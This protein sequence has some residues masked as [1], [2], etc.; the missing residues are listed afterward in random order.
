M[1]DN[2]SFDDAM[3]RAIVEYFFADPL[4]LVVPSGP[5]GQ[6]ITVNQRP[7][8][9][10]QLVEQIIARNQQEILKLVF[11]KIDLDVLADKLAEKLTAR[12]DAE[13][14]MANRVSSTWNPYRPSAWMQDVDDI[15]KRVVAAELADRMMKTM[16]PQEAA[17]DK[18]TTQ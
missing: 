6:M 2:F 5:D 13:L 1:P 3:K 4:P 15:A 12:F 9:L 7:S 14:D 8:P 10:R 11:A 16:E 17:A 18:E